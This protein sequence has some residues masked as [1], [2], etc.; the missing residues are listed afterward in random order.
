MKIR[1]DRGARH[2]RLRLQEKE[3][4][5]TAEFAS[6]LGGQQSG[7]ASSGRK[8][9]WAVACGSTGHPWHSLA[10]NGCWGGHSGRSPTFLSPHRCVERSLDLGVP[11][12]SS[13]R[14]R[15]ELVA[16]GDRRSVSCASG[17]RGCAEEPDSSLRAPR[18]HVRGVRLV[19]TRPAGL[20]GGAA[21]S[22]VASVLRVALV[23]P[24]RSPQ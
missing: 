16:S 22:G 2:F 13:P 1:A 20:Q 21:S 12:G 8:P 14:S 17:L 5:G 9:P 4:A 3:Q 18:R 15:G 10:S 6:P 19:R 24:A 11:W 7:H 23:G